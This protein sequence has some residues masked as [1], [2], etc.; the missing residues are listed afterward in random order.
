MWNDSTII[1][2]RIEMQ[3]SRKEVINKVLAQ[4]S[5]PQHGLYIIFDD[6][7][8]QDF[9][10]Y[11]W[12]TNLGMHINIELNGVEDLS[13]PYLL[14]IMRNK[15]HSRLIWLAKRTCVGD[16][17]RLAWI[18]AHELRHL[19]QDIQGNVLSRAS[20]FL[21][22][23]LGQIDI[24]EPKVPWIIPA[25]IDADVR[26]R[27][28]VN[29][30]F[31]FEQLVKFETSQTGRIDIGVTSRNGKNRTLSNASHGKT[32]PLKESGSHISK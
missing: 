28:I 17:L 16:E 5:I 21:Y 18:L 4:F 31:G 13:P 19:E 32:G 12:R 27:Q 22:E 3:A 15:T 8:H 23:T 26:A 14:K 11:I 20:N 29:D 2:Y 10:S 25:E 30:I 24:E 1:D 6:S 7:D 9:V